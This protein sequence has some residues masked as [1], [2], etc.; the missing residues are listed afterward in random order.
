MLRH[1][2]DPNRDGGPG[3]A[4]TYCGRLLKLERCIDRVADLIDSAECKACQ[5]SDDRRTLEIHRQE[6]RMIGPDEFY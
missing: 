4:W 2:P 6:Q 3:M 5:R 1:I